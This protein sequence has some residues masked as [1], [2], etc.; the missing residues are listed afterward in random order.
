MEDNSFDINLPEIYIRGFLKNYAKFLQVDHSK[1]LTDYDAQQLGKV[2]KSSSM[3]DSQTNEHEPKSSFGRMEIPSEDEQE[4][5]EPS[6]FSA[7]K[8]QTPPPPTLESEDNSRNQ[9][10][11]A[12]NKALY[13]KIGIVFAGV[14][15]LGTIL[16]V[17]IKL[18]S[19][20]SGSSE[21]TPEIAQPV[22]IQ[23]SD[24]SADTSSSSSLNTTAAVSN[25]ITLSA[26][27]TV[28]VIVEQTI[29][30]K[31]LYSGTLNADESISLEKNGPV[32]IR[33][34]NGSN[35]LVIKD[36]KE[37][38]PSEPGVGRTVVE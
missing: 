32:S 31:R 3:V 8:K 5:E 30:R 9:E 37:F 22:N 19:S 6:L 33:F 10:N 15:I 13:L 18:I 16:V 11:W 34:T 12:D 4:N 38:R 7:P 17:L 2:V 25:S 1:V 24:S 20:Q 28:T 23:S 35:L 36:G 26:S 29:D 27:G 21:I 14:L